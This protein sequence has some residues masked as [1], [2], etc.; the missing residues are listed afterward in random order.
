MTSV[1][2]EWDG[3]KN[4]ANIE[5]HGVSFE[6][7][8]AA[9]ADVNRVIQEDVGH[10]VRETRYFCYGKVDGEILTV[11]FTYR[12]KTIRIFGAAYWRKGK[13]TYEQK[14]R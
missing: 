6:D 10:S 13:K 8:R 5:K 1:R 14:N 9:F 12:G 4:A 3:A 7:A 2:F 11:R